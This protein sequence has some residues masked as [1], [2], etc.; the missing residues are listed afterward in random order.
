MTLDR[1]PPP[2]KEEKSCVFLLQPHLFLRVTVRRLAG[3][4][5]TNGLDVAFGVAFH[6]YSAR[7]QEGGDKHRSSA[8]S[9]GWRSSSHLPSNSV[10]GSRGRRFSNI[11]NEAGA[12]LHVLRSPHA[13]IRRNLLALLPTIPIFQAST[14]NRSRQLSAS[15]TLLALILWPSS[16]LRNLLHPNL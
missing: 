5:L 15:W 9:L 7:E 14:P 1:I 2:K 10:V 12:N 11:R 3:T 4:G 16:C 6:S 8:P 13:A